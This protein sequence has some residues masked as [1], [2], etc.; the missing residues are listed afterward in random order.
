MNKNFDIDVNCNSNFKP[1]Y[2]QIINQGIDIHKKDTLIN[3]LLF[4]FANE[5]KT[6]DKSLLKNISEEYVGLIATYVPMDCYYL[7]S[8][9]ENIFTFGIASCCGLVIYSNNNRFLMHISPNC[10][11]NQVLSLLDIL[12]LSENSEV[13][14]FPGSACIYEKNGNRFDYKKLANELRLLGNSVFI[15]IFKFYSGGIYFLGDNL[16]IDD[17]GPIC[18]KKFEKSD[19]IKR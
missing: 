1:K 5:R 18:I 19:I 13:Y 15:R 16:F 7:S 6:L 11:S 12:N 9:F 4:G 17:N 3:A 8:D 2:N 10:N 14:I